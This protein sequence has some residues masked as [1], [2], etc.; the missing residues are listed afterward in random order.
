M[1]SRSH[2]EIFSCKA[3]RGIPISLMALFTLMVPGHALAQTT[4]SIGSN[5]AAQAA[6]GKDEMPRGGCMP[7]GVTASGEMVFPLTCKAFL[8]QRRGPIGESKPASQAD[9][10]AVKAETPGAPTPL[11]ATVSAK[12][13]PATQSIDTESSSGSIIEGGKQAGI[14]DP[15][16]RRA[17]RSRHRQST[18]SS[19]RQHQAP[20]AGEASR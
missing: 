18:A 15:A 9:N 3:L 16:N 2:F 11:Q 7:I 5:P 10:P 8:E 6:S 17:K 20:G 4:D 13:V 14:E 1:L 12:D 19:S